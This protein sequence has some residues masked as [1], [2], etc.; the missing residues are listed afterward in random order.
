M[1]SLF[2]VIIAYV[3]KNIVAVS[4]IVVL[5]AI[6]SSFSSN[7]HQDQQ[8]LKYMRLRK[9]E[10]LECSKWLEILKILSKFHLIRFA[11]V[12]YTSK[13][14]KKISV[15][16]RLTQICISRAAFAAENAAI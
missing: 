16:D 11:I 8:V 5:L 13:S 2:D 12:R 9:V 1:I 6:V 3:T 7:V 4:I 10:S 15:T 14:D